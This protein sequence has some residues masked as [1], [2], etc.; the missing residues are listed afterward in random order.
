MALQ[1]RRSRGPSLQ[2][3]SATDL[4]K[5]FQHLATEPRESLWAT[6]VSQANE[7]TAYERIWTGGLLDTGAEPAEV[8]RTA[9]LAGDCMVVLINKQPARNLEPSPEGR[10]FTREL[11]RV[12]GY[13]TSCIR[14]GDH[15]EYRK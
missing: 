9:L 12:C 6:Y 11:R 13:S 1:L 5:A 7:V 8:T 3:K 4:A 10:R 14:E 15:R 2:G